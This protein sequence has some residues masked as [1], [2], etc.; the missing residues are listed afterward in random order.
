MRL[1]HAR[2]AL[3]LNFSLQF[4]SYLFM[5]VQRKTFFFYSC[6]KCAFNKP[7][8]CSFLWECGRVDLF[9]ALFFSNLQ[10]ENHH[11]RFFYLPP[12]LKNTVSGCQPLFEAAGRV[13]LMQPWYL[14]HLT[15]TVAGVWHSLSQQPSRSLSL[16]FG[17]RGK[18][19]SP[20]HPSAQHGQTEGRASQQGEGAPCDSLVLSRVIM[21]EMQPFSTSRIIRRGVVRQQ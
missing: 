15:S 5:V 2:Q 4:I 11:I 8:R 1:S 18:H 20:T 10:M 17:S 16:C 7:Q 6:C 9:L 14:L 19:F 3:S 21:M 12:L 13:S